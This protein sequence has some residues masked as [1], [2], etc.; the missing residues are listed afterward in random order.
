MMVYMCVCARAYLLDLII[1]N[2]VCYLIYRIMG[3]NNLS[4]S[5]S[6]FFFHRYHTDNSRQ[7]LSYSH[8]HRGL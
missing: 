4:L 5:F 6:C 1:M 7:S 3:L 8:K 2:P